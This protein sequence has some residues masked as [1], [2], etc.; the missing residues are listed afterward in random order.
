MGEPIT[1]PS[2]APVSDLVDEDS[3]LVHVPHLEASCQPAVRHIYFNNLQ[4]QASPYDLD[5]NYSLVKTPYSPEG[6]D[7]LLEATNITHQFPELTW[8]LR[9]GFPIGDM[10]PLVSSYT[11]QNLLGADIYRGVCDEY[12]AD[13]LAKGRFSGPYSHEQLYAKIGHFR[14]SPLQVVVKKGVNGTPDKYRV[15][16]HL[17]YRGSRSTSIN[18]EINSSEFPTEWGTAAE[19]AEI[20]RTLITFHLRHYIH[21]SRMLFVSFEHDTA[22]SIRLYALSVH[23]HSFEGT[24]LFLLRIYSLSHLSHI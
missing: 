1:A 14:S 22:W 19:F 11:P 7:Y 12:I 6:F 16:R 2:P 13:E 23:P 4:K 10:A 18:D 3:F 20:V 8:K 21:L 24:G 15:C 17:S 9:H 5:H